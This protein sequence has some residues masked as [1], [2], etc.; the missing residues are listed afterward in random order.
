M[1]IDTQIM[2]KKELKIF[3]TFRTGSNLVRS[4]LEL[5][6]NVLVHNNNY[7]YKHIPVPA[8][9]RGNEYKPFPIGIVSTV[10]DPF[11]FLDSTFRYCKT[12]NFLNIEA[13][14]SFD[15]FCYQRFIVFDGGFKDFPKYRFANPIQYWNSINH[16]LLSLPD[17]KNIVIRY[18]DLLENMGGE[19]RKIAKK[20]SLR[21][22]KGK[23]ILP[24]GVTINLGDPERSSTED[25]F[26]K[27]PYEREE[28]YLK[29]QYMERFTDA[30]KD[31]IYSELDQDL[32]EALAYQKSSSVLESQANK[33]TFVSDLRQLVVLGQERI[34]RLEANLVLERDASIKKDH[35]L[36]QSKAKVLNLESEILKETLNRES[37]VGGLNKTL[38]EE[39]KARTIESK[40][41]S[42][43]L[44]FEKKKL[45]ETNKRVG[46]LDSQL[47]EARD[48]VV[49]R[50]AQLQERGK[51]LA[52]IDK[53]LARKEGR[54]VEAL[55]SLDSQNAQLKDLDSQLKDRDSQ[56]KD[57]D[58]QLEDQDEK[59]QN[60]NTELED[61]NTQLEEKSTELETLTNRFIRVSTELGGSKKA[62]ESREADVEKTQQELIDSMEKTSNLESVFELAVQ[63]QSRLEVELTELKTKLK[64]G[65]DELDRAKNNYYGVRDSFSFKLGYDLVHAIT[66]PGKNTL[67]F[68][69]R[70]FKNLKRSFSK[71]EPSW[72]RNHEPVVGIQVGQELGHIQSG[73]TA[74]LKHAGDLNVACIFDEFTTEGYQGECNLL[75]LPLTDWLELFAS[76]QPD[77]LFVESAWRGNGGQWEYKIGKYAGQDGNELSSLISWCNNKGVPTVFWNKED[78]VHYDKFID[79]AKQFDVIFTTDDGRIPYYR[80]AAGHNN[81]FSLQFC[82]QPRL[83]NPVRINA[84]DDK[85]CFAGS[86]YLNI[87]DTRRREMNEI[88][89]IAKTYGLVIYDRNYERNLK[90]ETE[91]SFPARFRENIIGSLKY[92]EMDKAYK[93]YK[94]CLNVN[95]IKNSKTMFS[96]RV[97]ESMACGTPVLSTWSKGIEETF[98]DLVLMTGEKFD[99][100]EILAKLHEGDTAYKKIA[101]QGIREVYDHHLYMHRFATILEKAG[102]GFS[103]DAEYSVTMAC[104]VKNADEVERVRSLFNSQS[105]KQKYLLILL[106]F[107]EG[108]EEILNDRKNNQDDL[109]IM[110]LNSAQI[111]GYSLGEFFRS[112]H[113]SFINPDNYYGKQFLTDLVHA[114]IYTDAQVIG[115]AA[116][117]KYQD[118]KLEF[119]NAEEYNFTDRIFTTSSIM[120]FD[121]VR[122]H[123]LDD[124]IEFFGA[125]KSMDGLFEESVKCFS[126][127]A[128]NFMENAYLSH[129]DDLK[130]LCDQVDA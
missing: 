127:N 5:N 48:L 56:L 93:G 86:Y 128:F 129:S 66:R 123:R 61:R 51:Q 31:F 21:R 73:S 36:E 49:V 14:R 57:R 71:Q 19:I 94:Y 29:R 87:H 67:L 74:T 105:L 37:L 32:M 30:Q 40:E 89:D 18:E 69:F 121:L 100:E 11:A 106:D 130:T 3:G 17:G 23:F 7:A 8:D 82:A 109:I 118:D 92:N 95:S 58:S 25:Y 113:I 91:F 34:P 60:R 50:D 75:P 52:G 35:Q 81:V 15:E 2:P 38:L 12:N 117:F 33:A 101:V 79:S 39:K 76:T 26:Q 124:V 103:Q 112:T 59:L 83:H 90:S 42:D 43:A 96:R 70:V 53:K 13:G 22:K 62:L 111:L 27:S 88:L 6:Y 65:N 47:S 9:F 4:L 85:I 54:L 20:Y 98:G 45:D 68:P 107:N 41:L 16:N 108:V 28:Y 97:F 116:Y 125:Q 44:L 55:V 10:K 1:E 99:S 102:I 24:T 122:N 84:D 63:K 77:L 120:D 114:V 46:Q 78:P 119:S 64:H 104:V 110:H 72:G 80:E 126:V 115:K